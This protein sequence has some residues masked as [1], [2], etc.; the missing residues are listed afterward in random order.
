MGLKVELTRFKIKKGKSKV[1]DEWMEFLND[2]IDK[3]LLTLKDEKM[4]VESIFREKSEENE[5]LYWYSL[6]GEDGLNVEESQHAV[7]KK[8]LDY[9]YE[10]IDE[11]VPHLDLNK[12][13][14][15]IQENVLETMK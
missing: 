2:N 1:V 8:H 10:C 11:E 14:V 13:V 9:W 12:E 3:V 4:Y 5:F 15:M 6:Q 7:D